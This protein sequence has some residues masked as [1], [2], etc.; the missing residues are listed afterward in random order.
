MITTQQLIILLGGSPRTRL[1]DRPTELVPPEKLLE[2]MPVDRKFTCSEIHR[3][4]QMGRYILNKK[5]SALCEKG[6]LGR[7]KKVLK[8]AVTYLYERTSA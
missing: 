3:K 7:E 5:L 1:A 2:F 4:V 6:V 8:G